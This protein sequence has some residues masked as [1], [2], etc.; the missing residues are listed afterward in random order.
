M[1]GTLTWAKVR[2]RDRNEKLP[3][4]RLWAL[5]PFGYN[6]VLSGIGAFARIPGSRHSARLPIS[7]TDP[8]FC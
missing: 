4:F 3:R 7:L 6:P 1:P 5:G 2:I 8:S